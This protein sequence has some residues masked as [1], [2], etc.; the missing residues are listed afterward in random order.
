MEKLIKN[1]ESASVFSVKDLVSYEKGQVVSLTLA[2]RP[3]VGMTVFAFDQGEEISTHAASG[4]AM[5][6]VLEGKA[7]ITIDGKAHQVEEGEAIVMPKAI[8][9]AVKAITSFKMLLTV[10]KP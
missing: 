9:H 7:M 4:D 8:P 3:Q 6:Y 2:Q 10:V 5:A 1:V